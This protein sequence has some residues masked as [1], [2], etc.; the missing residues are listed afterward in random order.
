MDYDL[1]SAY[2]FGTVWNKAVPSVQ[3]INVCLP[4]SKAEKFRWELNLLPTNVATCAAATRYYSQFRT[5]W[6]SYCFKFAD[7]EAPE[8][9]TELKY[10]RQIPTTGLSQG[11]D[12]AALGQNR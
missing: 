9:R 11:A 4:R 12:V 6:S 7:L 10:S 2:S 8:T 1:F 5:T 3:S